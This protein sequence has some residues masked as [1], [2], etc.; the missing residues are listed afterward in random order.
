MQHQ[1]STVQDSTVTDENES[2]L[3]ETVDGLMIA[4]KWLADLLD[5]VT[6]RSLSRVRAHY[7][8]PQSHPTL[9][10]VTS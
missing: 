2:T 7:V 6:D 5:R 10:E 9:W 8:R 1:P 4:P 3:V